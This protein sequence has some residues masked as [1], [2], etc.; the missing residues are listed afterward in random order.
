MSYGSDW[1]RKAQ[2]IIPQIKDVANDNMYGPTFVISDNCYVTMEHGHFDK[3]EEGLK[4]L[5]LADF[6][7]KRKIS[8][9]E[10]EKYS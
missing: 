3:M 2:E 4:H 7:K 6:F 10:Y 1:T 8:K 5:T 9:E